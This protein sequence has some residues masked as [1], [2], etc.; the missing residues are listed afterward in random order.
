MA[1]LSS[2]FMARLDGLQLG[3]RKVLS[4]LYRGERR[5]RRRGSS[6]EFADYREYAYGDDIR[7]L[8]WHLM[9]RLD[10][11]FLKL[12]HDEEEL[13]LHLILDASKSMAFGSPSASRVVLAATVAPAP[14]R[15][16]LRVT[17]VIEISVK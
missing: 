17:V 1:L 13:R 11:L 2:D 4:G 14:A 3:M 5:S 10:R 15:N 7:H 16:V 6:V 9:A 12:F 8:D